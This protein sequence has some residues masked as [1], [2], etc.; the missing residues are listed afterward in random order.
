MA[1]PMSPIVLTMG[2]PGG[3]SGEITL[4]SWHLHRQEL[5]PFFVIDDIDRLSRLATDMGWPIKL[6]KLTALE[7][8]ATIFQNSLPVMQI[9][10][11][12]SGNAGDLI[13]GN[14]KAVCS[15]ID[16]ASELVQSGKCVAMV[17]NPIHKESLYRSGFSFPGHTEYLAH[18]ADITHEPI[19]MLASP[20]LRVV[21]VTRHVALQS[22]IT[23]LTAELIVETARTTANALIR[24]FGISHPRLAISGL[25]P[26]AGE[27]GH[28]GREEIE[29]IEPAIRQLKLENLDVFGPRSAD[30][31]FHPAARRQY[32]AAICMYHDQA[33]I[34]IKT[35][36]FDQAVNVTLGLPFIRTS[37]DHGT[38]IEIA[39]TGQ[40]DESSLV[41]AIKMAGKM[42]HAREFAVSPFGQDGTV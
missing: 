31:L 16:W 11:A 5:E 37:P 34:P 12:V 1:Q 22:A 19:M 6:E 2:E 27:G 7:D 29:V 13:E 25:N 39:G 20:N 3:I 18:L 10:E 38:A 26:H 8:T 4:K 30:T 42:A 9:E 15:A 32:D 14:S 35:L 41:A 36:D 40:A 17:T 28:M 23:K 24:D 33:L 21:T